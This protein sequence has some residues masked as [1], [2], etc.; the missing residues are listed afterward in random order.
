MSRLLL[1]GVGGPMLVASRADG[2]YYAQTLVATPPLPLSSEWAA[3]TVANDG[4]SPDHTTGFEQLKE[5]G[6]TAYMH[7]MLYKAAGVTFTTYTASVE[8]QGLLDG[9][10][11]YSANGSTW[12]V[13]DNTLTLPDNLGV[14][15]FTDYTRNPTDRAA[16]AVCLTF[17]DTVGS[18]GTPP[19]Y[20]HFT[21]FVAAF[22]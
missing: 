8:N 6:A 12:A 14:A 22:V 7:Y 1:L 5:N 4:V 18:S 3:T 10:A 21:E 20:L 9:Q 2:Y 11:T 16:V 17:R 19:C 15:T 13:W